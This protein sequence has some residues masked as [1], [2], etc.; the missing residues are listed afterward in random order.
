MPIRRS[1]DATIP[2]RSPDG[3][4]FAPRRSEDRDGFAGGGLLLELQR[5]PRSRAMPRRRQRPPKA[6]APNA[7]HPHRPRRP[8]HVRPCRRS[9]WG[10]APTPRCPM[11]IA[12]ELEVDLDQVQPRSRAAGRQALRQL[13]C[14]AFQVTGG[15][16]SVRAFWEP[17]RRAGATARTMLVIGGG[18]TWNVDRDLLPR[19]ER[20][21]SIHAPTGRKL[22]LWRPGRQGRQ[23]A[24]AGEGRAQGSE[25]LQA[26]RHA[27][28]APRHARQGQRHGGSAST[29]RL[30]GHEDR[31]R[32]RLPG[33]RRQ[34]RERRRQQGAGGQGRAPGRASRRCGRRGRATTC[35]RPRR[36]SRR[37][38]SQWDDGP[39]AQAHD[40]RHRRSRLDT[41]SQQDGV[42]AR[43]RRRRRAGA[44]QAP[45][46]RSRRSTSCRSS[47]TP[48][49]SR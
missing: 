15:S 44:W 9:R 48:P 16:T 21:R 17:L 40:R 43:K 24:G 31:H 10:R 33:L 13:R 23:T 26:D 28:Q 12:E 45:P 36:A 5:C 19:R 11:L 1:A 32:R 7:L 18:Q 25:G 22:D 14:S 27:G 38:R 29:R 34:A 37:S 6:F 46:R 30:P 41:A 3:G 49:W 8:R 20:A 42:V 2:R 47:P 39:N 4:C 35:G